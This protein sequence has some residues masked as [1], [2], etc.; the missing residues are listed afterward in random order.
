MISQK[1]EQCVEEEWQAAEA[2]LRA[3]QKL[4]GGIERFEALRKAGQL[5]YDADKRRREIRNEVGGGESN[6]AKPRKS[7]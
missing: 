2:A 3:A 6:G 5:R 7:K 4:P 1:E